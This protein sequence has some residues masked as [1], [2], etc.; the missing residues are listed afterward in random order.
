MTHAIFSSYVYVKGKPVK[1][2]TAVVQKWRTVCDKTEFATGNS[3]IW[4]K[5]PSSPQRQTVGLR[6]IVN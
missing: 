5:Y 2:E 6:N 3:G 4:V 1:T